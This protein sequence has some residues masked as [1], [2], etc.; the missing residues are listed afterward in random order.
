LSGRYKQVAKIS[1]S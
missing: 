1:L